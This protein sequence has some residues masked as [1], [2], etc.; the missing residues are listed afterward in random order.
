MRVLA[1]EAEWQG[2]ETALALGTF[3]GVHLGHQALLRETVRLAQDDRLSALALTFEQHPMSVLCPER[4]PL[5][6]ATT[7][8][9]I[10]L[11]AAM[12]LDALVLRPFDRA[13]AGSEPE[14]Y[15]EMLHRTLAPRALVVGYNYSFGREGRG[16]AGLLKRL[17]GRYGYALRVIE[18]V[19][20]GGQ[21]ISSTLIREEL[22]AGRVERA[23]Q[24]LGRP[25]AITGE[26]MHGK[27]VG[28]TLG[29]PTAN[30]LL[31]A[32][33]A[34]PKGGVYACECVLPGGM[35]YPAVLNQGRHPT[36]PAGGAT[37]E[38]HLMG[39]AGD[40]Y[41]RS[42][43]VRYRAFLR[44]EV[45][46]PSVEALRAQLQRDIKAAQNWFQLRT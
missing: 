37:I 8:E 9:K 46:F 33:R 39:Y 44:P 25:Y 30:L 5:Q 23:A 35:V 34:L 40:L 41:G 32:G 36:L 27:R 22:A 10:E 26:V 6:L 42:I 16:D 45:K 4:A 11:M 21:V 29:F 2:G 1:L 13:F 24:L 14:A 31:P 12:G 18:P 38:V 3:D 28:R 15:V 43:Q 20:Q 7:E 19:E 17:S